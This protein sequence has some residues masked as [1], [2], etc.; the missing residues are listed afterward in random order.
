MKLAALGEFGLIERIRRAAGKA[1]SIPLGIGDDCAALT[2]PAGELLLSTTDLLIEDVHFRRA[3]TSML[4][5][6]RKSVSVNVSDIAA[7]GGTPQAL[8]LAVGIP[9]DCALEDLQ[10]FLD[11]FLAACGDYGATL[12][13]GDTCRSPGPLFISVTA[14]GRVPQ[15]QMV[16]RSGARPGDLIFVSGTLGDSA[17]A[18]H[19]LQLGRMPEPFFATRHFDPTARTRLGR[20]LSAAGLASAM[21]DLSDGLLADLG[22]ILD[23]SRAGAEVDLEHLPL[24]ASFRAVLEKDAELIELALSGGEDYELLFTA[25]PAARERILALA[26]PDCDI[27]EV[28]RITAA[29]GDL[30]VKD[31]QGDLRHITGTGFSH[32]SV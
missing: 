10:P 17:Y 23:A 26:R 5:L 3:W 28:G 29:A 7:M 24:S 27:R 11:G 25:P 6:G 8:L 16:T 2:V 20:E 31:G 9:G 30:H 4:D 32:F 13:G 12:A 19:E 21:I 15:A 18:L 1:P 14:T 22:H